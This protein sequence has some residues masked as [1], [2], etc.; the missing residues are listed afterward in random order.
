MRGCQSGCSGDF[1]GWRCGKAA[2]GPGGLALRAGSCCWRLL[3]SV[4]TSSFLAQNTFLIEQGYQGTD[5]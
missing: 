1:R 3:I 5:L 2:R 4:S